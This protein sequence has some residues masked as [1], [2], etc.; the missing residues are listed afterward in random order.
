MAAAA[1][2][3]TSVK[4]GFWIRTVAY[5][6]DALILGVVVNI[7]TSVAFR[8]E[9]VTSNGLSLLV[10]LLYFGY[11]WSGQGGGQTLGMRIFS[12]KVVKTDGAMLTLTQALVRWVGLLVS[13]LVIF[14]GVIWVAFDTNKQGWHDKIAGTYV[15]KAK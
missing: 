2:I 3:D 10:S 1:A 11:L 9:L 12:L 4:A 5:I 6:I 14:I 7:V 13:F 15:V 8:G